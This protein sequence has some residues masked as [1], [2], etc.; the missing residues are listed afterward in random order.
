MCIR[1]TQNSRDA[2]LQIAHLD[3]ALLLQRLK[4]GKG[5]LVSKGQSHARVLEHVVKGKILDQIL[6]AVDVVVGVLER[7]L[8]YECRWVASLGGRGV[9]RAGVAALG[10]DEGDIAVLEPVRS[11]FRVVAPKPK[12]RLTSTIIFLMNSVRLGST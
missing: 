12:S 7:G 5:Q 11:C 1:P 3:P 9:V 4:V 2:F 8:D 6:G 10:L